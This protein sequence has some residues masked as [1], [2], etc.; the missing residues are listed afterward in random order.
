MLVHSLKL[1]LGRQAGRQ[2]DEA[3]LFVT[4]S[5]SSPQGGT[6]AGTSEEGGTVVGTGTKCRRVG[7]QK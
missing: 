5:F 4:I 3:A 6:L 2:A 7:R 1:F